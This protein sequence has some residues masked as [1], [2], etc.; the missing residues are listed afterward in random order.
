MS[1]KLLTKVS[2]KWFFLGGAGC[3]YLAVIFVNPEPGMEMV[4]KALA[5][6]ANLIPVFVLVFVV[7]VLSR[8]FFDSEK[9]LKT[10]GERCGIR[11]WIL[12]VAGGILSAGPVYMWYPLLIDLKEKGMKTSLVATFLYNR[13]VKIPLLP[14]MIFYFGLPF[15]VVLTCYIIVFSII[16][17]ILVE[18]LLS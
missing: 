4:S 17:G 15:T 16:N 7:M 18:R 2:A 10:V 1:S 11:G 14:L 5:I 6:F 12:S 8:M 9:V 13:A 3:L